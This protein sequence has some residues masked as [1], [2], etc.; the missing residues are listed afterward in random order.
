M[1]ENYTE[2]NAQLWLSRGKI[3]WRIANL[4]P[5]TDTQT[6]AQIHSRQPIYFLVAYRVEA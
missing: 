4:F 3:L 6:T 5:M 1:K 2:R